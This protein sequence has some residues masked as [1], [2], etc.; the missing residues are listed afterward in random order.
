MWNYLTE[1]LRLRNYGCYTIIDSYRILRY[2]NLMDFGLKVLNIYHLDN[3][4]ILVV[5]E[6]FQSFELWKS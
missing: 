3:F 1:N 2:L 5:S 6:L 4:N